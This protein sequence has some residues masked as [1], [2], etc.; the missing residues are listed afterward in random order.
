MD[1]LN[2]KTVPTK[3]DDFD[4]EVY[5]PELGETVHFSCTTIRIIPMGIMF[6]L[7]SPTIQLDEGDE[8]VFIRALAGSTKLDFL[9]NSPAGGGS[10]VVKDLM[11]LRV[12]LLCSGGFYKITF[13]NTPIQKKP[14]YPKRLR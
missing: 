10:W 9:L 6:Y 1:S 3:I 12:Q 2:T 13:F 8:R 14:S 5:L 7:D 11:D 4:E